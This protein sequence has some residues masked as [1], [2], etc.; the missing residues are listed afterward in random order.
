M[1]PALAQPS[2]TSQVLPQAGGK[3]AQTHGHSVLPGLDRLRLP[4]PHDGGRLVFSSQQDPQPTG[5]EEDE[6]L[7]MVM[8]QCSQSRP[9][10][11]NH[12]QHVKTQ[13]PAKSLH[14]SHIFVLL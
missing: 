10:K 2:P 3:T 9:I 1:T 6:D 11:D 14:L 5:P 13:P 8:A 7:I 12:L 4:R